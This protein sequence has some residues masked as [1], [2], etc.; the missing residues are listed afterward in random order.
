MISLLK[1]RHVSKIYGERVVVTIKNSMKSLCVMLLQ[2][3][4]VAHSIQSNYIFCILKINIRK[5]TGD[6]YF[7]SIT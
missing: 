1:N 5:R 4:I 7:F 2:H 6:S 3:F